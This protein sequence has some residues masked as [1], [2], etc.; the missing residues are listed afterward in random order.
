MDLF[1]S[2]TRGDR[3]LESIIKRREAVS[4][5]IGDSQPDLYHKLFFQ[6]AEQ[7]ANKGFI[8]SEPLNLTY[9]ETSEA[10]KKLAYSLSRLVDVKTDSKVSFIFPNYAELIISKLSTSLLGHVAVPLNYRLNKDEMGY[11]INQSD[12]SYI[13]MIDRWRNSNYIEML[14]EICPEVFEGKVSEAFPFLH[15]IIVYSPEGKKYK[16]TYDFYDLIHSVD[17]SEAEKFVAET[18]QNQMISVDALSDIMYTSGTTS[19][20]K[21]VL[22]THDMVWRVALGTCINRGYQKGRRIY[23][24]IPLYHCFGYI[25]G[26]VAATMVGGGVILQDDFNEEQA[27]ELIAKYKVDDML[28]VPTIA[29]RLLKAYKAQNKKLN[30]E[31]MYCAGAEVPISLWEELKYTIGI[32]ELITGYGMTELASGVLQTDPEDHISYLVNFVGKTIPGGHVGLEELKGYNIEFKIRDIES[33]AFLPPG[34][35]GELVCRGP[36]VTEGYYK[37]PVETE[38]AI[39]GGWLNT[40]DLAIINENGYVTLTGRLKEIY[41]IGAENV[42]PKE[43]EDVLTSHADVN[44][45]YVIGVPDPVLGEVGLAWV[46]LEDNSNV[47]PNDLLQYVSE[48]LARFKVPKLIQIIEEVELPKTATGKIQK[49][50]LK[51]LFSG[52][53]IKNT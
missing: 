9:Y 6:K 10:V 11:L 41:R 14:R 45:A 33:R 19:H 32:Q 46:V 30:L 44:Q 1:V 8:Y 49:F 21:G 3:L 39:E 24:P 13:I 26:L 47:T 7:Y 50:K 16:G 52:D 25:I 34:K 2:D 53:P 43:I 12:T 22:V 42:A 31:A 40:G 17:E 20:P 23:V 29:I 35:E 4:R 36:I 27:L 5:L 38:E 15:K 28:C 51:D 48:R 37:K 18:L